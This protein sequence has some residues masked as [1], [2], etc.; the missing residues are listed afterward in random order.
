MDVWYSGDYGVSF[1]EYGGELNPLGKF[2]GHTWKNWS[3]IPT[4]R[5][6]VVPP[7]HKTSEMDAKGINGKADV[8]N[9]L[10]GFPLFGNREGSWTFYIADLNDYSEYIKDS[11]A[12]NPNVDRYVRD[13]TALQ[14]PNMV[15][16]MHDVLLSTT[17][18]D[19]QTKYSQL[20]RMLHAKELAIVLD[21]DPNHFYKGSV[22]IESFV[23]SNDG[24]LNGLTIKYDLF[25]YKFK[26][27]E[28][29]LT[30]DSSIKGVYEV[31]PLDAKY[32][33]ITVPWLLI[34]QGPSEGPTMGNSKVWFKND[35]LNINLV[36]PGGS[37]FNF[38]ATVGERIKM[39]ASYGDGYPTSHPT[40]P[41]SNFSGN[42]TVI[43]S[44]C[45]RLD[46]AHQ[47]VQLIYREGCL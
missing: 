20:L 6:F 34:V 40:C 30:Y 3:L 46:R 37:D 11:N 28:T 8:S 2:L 24:S 18:Q 32:P 1:Y 12:N 15:P 13:N 33:M 5:P 10:L 21:E 7:P 9:K 45:D 14:L 4:A 43:W 29:V 17:K 16:P 35:E 19:F 47:S 25:P 41:I 31:L 23:A 26:M 38:A 22:Q 36:A 42:N 44:I 39:I 27:E